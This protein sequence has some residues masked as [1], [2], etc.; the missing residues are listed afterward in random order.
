[1]CLND[2]VIYLL[3]FLLNV[4]WKWPTKL[5]LPTTVYITTEDL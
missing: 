5:I 1:M 3:M 4:L 2:D